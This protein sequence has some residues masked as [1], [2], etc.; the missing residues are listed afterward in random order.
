VLAI[1]AYSAIQSAAPHDIDTMI[2]EVF[3][4]WIAI[5]SAAR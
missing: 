1:T 2:D 5:S 3:D 4:R